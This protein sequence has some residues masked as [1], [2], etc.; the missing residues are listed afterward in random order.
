[1]GV[2][3]SAGVLADASLSR[4][5]AAAFRTVFAPKVAGTWNLHQATAGLPLRFF[6]MFAAGAGLLGSPGQGNYAAANAFQDSFAAWRQAQGLPGLAIDWG[7]WAEVG[8][9]ARTRGLSERQQ[10]EGIQP[11]PLREGLEVFGRLL[12]RSGP[13]VGVLPVDWARFVGTAR[14]ASSQ[15]QALRYLERL[16]P[17]SA[18][19]A[20][21]AP[22]PA[23][24]SGRKLVDEL[25]S[26]P[27][28]QWSVLAERYVQEAAKRILRMPPDRRIDPE[29]PLLD[30]GLDSLLAVELKNDIMDGGVDIPVARVM[31]GPSVR[32]IGQMVVTTVE[33][34][35]LLAEAT[36]PVREVGAR[37]R[38]LERIYD[39]PVNIFVSHFA[40]FVFGVLLVVGG[41]VGTSLWM[42]M[43][44]EGPGH[45]RS[46]G[47][48][49]E[50][51]A[52]SKKR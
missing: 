25:S 36:D 16:V 32:Q 29:V 2:I 4:L 52:K 31:T 37:D 40:A 8:M 48:G 13:Q 22:R 10:S 15:G 47:E 7:S 38:A 45:S 3:H 39:P 24:L 23:T 44:D 49:E 46:E 33:E 41:Y 28:A 26:S 42:S 1:V 11:I 43:Q 35:G 30:L 50:A 34:Q 21:S 20:E 27:R 17:T 14:K 5:D 18:P 51:P 19:A 12:G 6:V 9:A